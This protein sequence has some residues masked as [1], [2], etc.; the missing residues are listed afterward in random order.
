MKGCKNMNESEMGFCFCYM[1]AI[2][3]VSAAFVIVNGLYRLPFGE[4]CGTWT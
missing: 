4:V 3:H 2:C 1:M